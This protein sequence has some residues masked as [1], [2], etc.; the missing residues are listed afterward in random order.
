MLDLADYRRTDAKLPRQNAGPIAGIGTAADFADLIFAKFGAINAL[1][2]H[3]RAVPNFIAIVRL[4]RVVTKIVE[5]VVEWV[6]VQMANLKPIWALA[7]KSERYGMVDIHI[8]LAAVWLWHLKSE[9]ILPFRRLD[10]SAEWADHSAKIGHFV[11]RESGYL[12]PCFHRSN[13]ST[14]ANEVQL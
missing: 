10:H 8:P 3:R 11:A 2:T 14:R 9:V 13:H 12:D 7:Y 6:S 5:P 1:A 4:W